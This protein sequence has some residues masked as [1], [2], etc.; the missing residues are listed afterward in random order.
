MTFLEAIEKIINS[1]GIFEFCSDEDELSG[2]YPS[3]CVYQNGKF[4]GKL[5]WPT[6]NR[7]ASVDESLEEVLKELK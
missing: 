5:R 6:D 3:I 2:K 7:L 4:V 1:K